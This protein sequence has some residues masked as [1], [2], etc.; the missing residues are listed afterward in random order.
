MRRDSFCRDG[1]V[2]KGRRPSTEV[3]H[4]IPLYEGGHPTDPANLIGV[5]HECHRAKSTEET[6]DRASA[7]YEPAP[8]ASTGTLAAASEA[9]IARKNERLG[10]CRTLF[11]RGDDDVTIAAA[12]GI[13]A[14][15]VSRL[16]RLWAA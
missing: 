16:R 3:D 10:R 5:C 4:V 14:A 15:A 2:C 9:W 13:S 6:R 11:E 12:T 1:R 7:G 8:L